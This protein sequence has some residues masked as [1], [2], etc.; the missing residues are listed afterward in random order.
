MSWQTV[1]LG[2]YDWLL[3]KP[4]R[5]LYFGGPTVYGYGFWGGR[6]PDEIC[7]ELTNVPARHWN[8]HPAECEELLDK[9]LRA[10]LIALETLAYLG[11]LYKVS[12]F[13]IRL[14]LW[15]LRLSPESWHRRRT[16]PNY[17]MSAWLDETPP[18]ELKRRSPTRRRTR[19]P[20]RRERS[21]S[22][23]WDQ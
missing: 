10:F 18:I 14:I 4:L 21:S 8:E 20:Q 9:Q 22:S 16:P 3:V 17:R 15:K 12:A 5:K 1:L 6:E 19:S 11:L 23:D 13:I 2:I 7:A